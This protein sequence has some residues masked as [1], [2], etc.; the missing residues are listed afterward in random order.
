METANL[1]NTI[2]TL[3][4]NCVGFVLFFWAM[5]GQLKKHIH[6]FDRIVEVVNGML[7]RLAEMEKTQQF[8]D[9][10]L[11]RVEKEQDENRIVRYP[12]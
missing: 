5:N 7:I 10:R 4:G 11:D 2:I 9:H 3:V 6:A 1:T 8:H 12:K